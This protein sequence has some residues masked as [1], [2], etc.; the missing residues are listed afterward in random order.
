MRYAIYYAPNQQSL[1][2][3]LGSSWLGR[4]AYTREIIKQPDIPNLKSIALEP[5][6]YGLHATLKAPFHL[7][8]GTAAKDL[9]KA[10]E[11]LSAS[12]ARV[13]ISNLHLTVENGFLALMPSEMDISLHKL[14]ERCVREFDHLRAPLT[15]TELLRRKNT[16]MTSSQNLHLLNFGYPYV[17]DEFRF[18]ITLSNKLPSDKIEWLM[19]LA[20]KHFAPVIGKS[21]HIDGLSIFEE[22]DTESPMTISHQFPFALIEP[23]KAAS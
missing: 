10:A 13:T 2:H 6:H 7:K 11:I 4:D 19:P 18:H 23:V 5:A 3:R 1:L 14:A 21:L 20:Y 9:M 15:N 17:L 12:Q 22:A 8:E 16:R